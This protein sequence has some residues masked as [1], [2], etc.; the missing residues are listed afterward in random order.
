[1]LINK[2]DE[3]FDT[4]LDKLFN[5]LYKK[6][7]FKK[8]NKDANFVVFQDKILVTINEFIKIIDPNDIHKIIK[9]QIYIDHIYNIIKRYCAFYIYLGIGYYYDQGLDLFITNIIETSKNQKDSK[10][11]LENFFNSDN[12]SKII[13]FYILIQNIKLLFEFKSMDKIKI[14]ISNNPLK[15][16]KVTEL[17]DDLGE[18][19]IINYIFIK[20]NFH[21]ILKTIIFRLIYIKDEK[22]EINK[23]LNEIEQIEGEY[24]YIEII[25]SNINKIADFN[26]IQ[27]CLNIKQIKNGLAEEIYNYL[28]ENQDNKDIILNENKD[29]INYLF[30]NKI[31]IPISEDFLRYHKDSE[32]YDVEQHGKKEDTKIKYVI[33]KIDNI[34]NY[35]SH[36]SIKDKINIEKLFY[37]NLDPRMCVLYND[38]EEI[39]I[40]Q[41]LE[42]SEN[43]LDYDNLIDL[44]NI[45]RY[46][47]VNF[48]NTS[49]EFIKLRTTIPVQAIRYINLKKKKLDSIET[50]FGNNNLDLNVV[51]IAFNPSRLNINHESLLECFMIK[52]CINVNSVTKKENGFL[53]FINVLEKIG[54]K[55]NSELINASNNLYY[56]LFNDAKDI[57]KL[58]E[59]I[60]YNK[61]DSENNFKIMLSKIYDIW[62]NIIKKKFL[63]YISTLDKI[64]IYDLTKLI[65]AYEIKYFNFNL[66]PDLRNQLINK[67][68]ISKFNEIPIIE[69]IT[70]NIIPG[71]RDKIILLPI[72]HISKKKKDII[73]VND[74]NQNVLT[75][76]KHSNAIC[77]H[78]I[79]WGHISKHINNNQEDSNQSV[80]E[81]IKK[82][83]K[84]NQKGEY[85]CKSCNEVLAVGKFIKEGSYNKETDEF[86]TTSLIIKQKLSDLP[87]YANL[88][89]VI[90]NLGKNLEK[91][92]NLTDITYYLGNNQ[93]SIL[94]RKIVIK[95]TID[96]IL[97]HTQYIKNQPS[98]RIEQMNKKYNIKKEYTNLFFFELKNEIFLT[99]SLDTDYYKLIK[100][101]NVMIY[102]IF[103]VI[104][105]L[106]SGQILNFR[107]D[108]KCNYFFYSKVSNILFK[109]LYL[110]KND[111]EKILL[112]D[113]PLLSYIIYYFSCILSNNNLW[114]YNHSSKSDA[115]DINIVNI[116]KVIVHTIID[117]I[118]SIIEANYDKNKNYLYELIISRFLIKLTNTFNDANL[119]NKINNEINKK[120]LIDVK[121]NKISFITKK[122][123]YI[124]IDSNILFDVDKNV[125]YCIASTKILNKKK[126]NIDKNQINTV[127]NCD[128][129]NFHSW[130]FENK[131]MICTFCKKNFCNLIKEN[132]L[133]SDTEV[134]INY[135][136]II[137]LNFIKKLTKRYCLNNEQHY[138]DPLTGICK[139]CNINPDNHKYTNKELKKLENIITEKNEKVITNKFKEIKEYENKNIDIKNKNKIIITKFENNFKNDVLLKYTS[140]HLENY[141]NDFIKKLIKILGTKIKIKNNTIYLKDTIYIVNHDYLG[142]ILKSPFNILSCDNIILT[143]SNHPLFNKDIIYYKDKANNVF[144]YYDD[145]NLQYLGYSEDNKILKQNN[146][147]VSLEIKYSI[148]DYLSL[149][150]LENRH[151]N[152]YSLDSSLLHNFN[153]NT[154]NIINDLSRIRIINLKQIIN[155]T[156]S[157]INAISNHSKNN[158]I[159]NVK[160]KEIINE[161]ITKLKNLNLKNNQDKVFKHSKHICNLVNFK[162]IVNNV[163]ITLNKNYLKNDFLNNMLKTDSK[164]IYYIILN[165]NKLLEYNTQP[166]IESEIAHLIIKIIEFITDLYFKDINY[167][168]RK[169]EYLVLTDVPYIDE[170]IKSFGLYNDLVNVNEIDNEKI[171]EQN[172][173][174]EEQNNA[175]DIDDYDQDEDIDNTTQAFS[176]DI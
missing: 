122:I 149:L 136:E 19:Y 20:D 154:L 94:H 129:G 162:E 66:N 132:M 99:S 123:D 121:T 139:L 134:N 176:T 133:I 16:S 168:I 18:D 147:N 41:K 52:N 172:E 90:D 53:S 95:D 141:I 25:T 7:V 1:M 114:L 109:D 47:Y 156:Q 89:K 74:K 61:N 67:V 48:K 38:N 55:S 130:Y 104:T 26:I 125:Q 115:K 81:F 71:K 50:R 143:M 101:N 171:K 58:N 110:R 2:I 15:F 45:R 22:L 87:K 32:K 148:K 137:K 34:K 158:S 68:L 118:N 140:N 62:A 174:I 96:L 4:I 17:I 39:K 163:D 42:N 161:F 146:K 82:Y 138:F 60:D 77:N 135:Y 76:F 6:D 167:E 78:Y 84:E 23:L 119:I 169:F 30:T 126:Y 165:F 164:L 13:N 70:D 93:T 31:I 117:L 113:L 144:V 153:P 157:I 91:I 51:G 56:W 155:R 43:M 120:I 103:I 10:I 112:T 14:I 127:T 150:G 63:N 9:K 107:N 97:L 80:F 159:Y 83:L 12:N 116:Q 85:I 65:N 160:E 36:I 88:K 106:N 152:L 98:D 145:V 33:N 111:K 46:A 59:Y 173:D 151:T 166:A 54:S 57:P 27:K 124:S 100:F 142:N 86:M 69:D 102:L 28:L 21:N 128:D 29:F 11:R 105:E 35:Y 37:K 72:V 92:A 24:K 64:T 175:L 79:Q 8:L 5:F 3:L 131:N 75:E 40:I 44:K 108:K 49:K 73:I 170:N